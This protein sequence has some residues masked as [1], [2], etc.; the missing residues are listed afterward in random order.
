[1]TAVRLRNGKLVYTNGESYVPYV[2]IYGRMNAIHDILNYGSFF[3]S[4]TMR[5]NN[6]EA[7]GHDWIGIYCPRTKHPTDK[8]RHFSRMPGH[9]GLKQAAPNLTLI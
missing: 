1:M 6:P 5:W 2:R 3:S 7:F 4:E 9:N 8:N